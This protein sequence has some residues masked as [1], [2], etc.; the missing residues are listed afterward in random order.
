MLTLRADFLGHA[1][2]YRP[3]AD[4]LQNADVKLGPMNREELQRAIA[5]PA[6]KLGMLIEEGL[7]DRILDAVAGEPGNL[8]LLEFAL[9][10]LWEKPR[11][12]RLTHAA[13]KEIGGVESA[14]ALHAQQVYDKLKPQEQ[15]LAQR[16]FLALTQ[17]GVGTEDTRRQVLKQD[18][19]QIGAFAPVPESETLV[20]SVIQQL[21]AAKLVVTSELMQGL[22]PTAVVDV[23]H[24]ALI[25]HWPLLRQWVE[26]NR[27]GLVRQR[28][29]EAAA[30]EWQNQGE[31]V[32]VAY[33]LQG[34]KLAEAENFSRQ[35]A[36][37]VPLSSL[38]R[39]YIIVSQAAR[40][41]LE[42]EQEERQ[43]RELEQERKARQAA[44][45]TAGA[46]IVSFVVILTSGGFAWW[47]R[48]QSLRII[49]DVS[50]GIDVGTPQ[51]LAVLPDFL[52]IADRYQQAGDADRA[53]SYYRQILTQ[54]SKL[55][56]PSR[57]DPGANGHFPL[58]PQAQQKL[59]DIANQA[60][61][62]L[63]AT[64]HKHRLPQLE[65][66]LKNRQIGKLHQNTSLLDFENQY[67]P[68]ALQ[69]TYTI[70]MR[71]SGAK[72]DLNDDGELQTPEEAQRMPCET[73][74]EIE[75]LWRQATQ[76]RCGWYGPKDAY[77]APACSELNGQ[78]LTT[79]IFIVPPFDAATDRLKSCQI[80]SPAG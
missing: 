33:L 62:S 54:T 12:G 64:I 70:L 39:G 22:S 21:A 20:E 25:R 60:E 23:V 2:S 26:E 72:A 38:A 13:Y 5:Q 16:I 27:E 80:G 61:K 57:Q 36:E 8:P 14:L 49:Q 3:L 18:L 65:T 1:L 17:L 43:R 37:T 73:L 75:Q 29:I 15:R 50:L 42:Q 53:L 24:E 45:R 74:K 71:Q 4:G 63:I 47:Q 40:D 6:Q 30:Q 41:R 68:G 56:N 52:N 44:Q 31:P 9:T 28:A 51:L 19:L 7:S 59:Q 32:D 79:T 46:A 10:L 67:E 35:W 55:L 78:T 48:Q 11:N 77:I 76:N 34:P 69:T 58:P 66:Q